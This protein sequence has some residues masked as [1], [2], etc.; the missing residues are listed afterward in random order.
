MYEKFCPLIKGECVREC[1]FRDNK[2]DVCNINMAVRSL[3]N[4]S[5]LAEDDGINVNALLYEGD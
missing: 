1:E 5:N 4:L 3:I 2:V